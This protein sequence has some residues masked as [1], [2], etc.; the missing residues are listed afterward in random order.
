M[1]DIKFLTIEESNLPI[2]LKSQTVSVI[3]AKPTRVCNANCSYCSSPPLEEMGL[4]WEPEWNFDIFKKYFDKVFPYVV[5][6]AWWIWHGGEPMLM[7]PDFYEKT[8]EYAKTQMKKYNKTINFS[9]QTNLLGY[10]TNKWFNVFRNI[11]NGSISTS[12][13]PDE[14]NRKIKQSSENYS[15]VFKNSLKNLTNDGFRPLVIGV[16]SEENA[17]LMYK[18]Y[19]WALQENNFSIRLNYCHPSGRIYGE[20]EMISNETYSKYLLEIYDRWIEDAPNFTITPLDQMFKKV[21]NLDGH[22]HCPWL[23]DCGGKF[24]N[25]EPNGDVY[26]CSEFADIGTEYCYGNL[27]D[28]SKTV[29]DLLN[30]E[31][32]KKIKRRG[33]LLP[34]SCLNCEHFEECE[35]GCMRDSLLFENGLYGKFY[36]C[37]TWKMV[38][39]KIKETILNGKA[40]KILL[41]YNLEPEKIKY[42]V[43]NKIN[44]YFNFNM[45]EI[46]TIKVAS[47]NKYGFGDNF[48]NL[49]SSNY[50]E[51]GKFIN[52]NYF[53]INK[54]N[55]K[56]N[57]KHKKINEKINKIKIKVLN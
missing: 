16:Y 11:F 52:I 7:G 19:E 33:V 51:L 47:K 54:E 42:N 27:N 21:M 53:D 26:N 35:G 44:L 10:S 4:D 40:D 1:K 3:I 43:L 36:Y 39:T 45:L 23:K 8:Y 12:F 14:K 32:A 50:D 38:L 18:M 30:S 41:N 56:E 25:I 13:D 46:E 37:K 22:G 17:H 48:H 24:M 49:N 28:E 20:K 31:P 5:D 55:N 29:L 9:M 2:N 57:N 15:K 34:N 6:G